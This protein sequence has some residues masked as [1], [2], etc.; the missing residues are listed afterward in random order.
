MPLDK[1]ELKRDAA[2]HWP[3]IFGAV[4]LPRDYTRNQPCPSCGGRDRFF[5]H[6]DFEDTGGCECRKCGLGGAD[7]FAVLQGFADMTFTRALEFVSDQLGLFEPRTGQLTSPVQHANEFRFPPNE[8]AGDTDDKRFNARSHKTL[9]EAVNAYVTFKATREETLR[10]DAIYPV[11]F[12]GDEPIYAEA[13]LLDEH[14]RKSTPCF[15]RLSDTS[16]TNGTVH[17]QYGKRSGPGIFAL[18]K[19]RLPF[20]G[21]D[22][23]DE[24]LVLV[25]G[26]KCQ[27]KATEAGIPAIAFMGGANADKL[28]DFDLGSLKGKSVAICFD[29]DQDGKSERWGRDAAAILM[30]AG[31]ESVKMID[32]RLLEDCPSTPKHGYDIADYLAESPS[33]RAAQVILE[34]LHDEQD[35]MTDWRRPI[36]ERQPPDN[37]RVTIDNNFA[38]IETKEGRT[39]EANA[40]RFV[41]MFIDEVLYCAPWKSWVVWDG[42]RWRRDDTGAIVAK[43]REVGPQVWIEANRC[44]GD[45]A[46]NA[47]RFAAK[48][49]SRQSIKNMVELAKSDPDIVVLP[50]QL[51]TQPMLFNCDNGTIDLATGKLRPH[52]LLDRLTQCSPVTYREDSPSVGKWLTF[53]DT[54]LGDPETTR[55]MQRL[56]GY[57]LTGSIDEHKLVIAHGDGANGKSTMFNILQA[58]FGP[59]YMITIVKSVLL[60]KPQVASHQTETMNLFGARVALSSETNDS[61]SL[62]EATVK[63]LTGGDTIRGSRKYEQTWQFDPTHKLILQTNHMPRIKGS[64]HAIWRRVLKIPFDVTFWDEDNGET[65]LPEHKCD[66]SLLGQLKAELSGIL[67]W[68]VIGC[69]QWQQD[70]LQPSKKVLKATESYKGQ[71]CVVGQF[72]DECCDLGIA[73]QHQEVKATVYE[74]YRAWMTSRGQ[75]PLSKPKFTKGLL[76]IPGISDFRDNDR[77]YLGLMIRTDC[78]FL[79]RNGSFSDA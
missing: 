49:C 27:Q 17:I 60:E 62:D 35:W 77:K 66:K 64:D 71:Q 76:R 13:R 42:K 15:Q 41:R 59:Q 39:D 56:V 1:N 32:L 10:I 14:G 18:N 19:G 65:G 58:M 79:E 51:D 38:R 4:G 20:W 16:W 43:A 29:L 40:R 28:R 69:M 74:T 34:V 23:P 25:E 33:G 5:A 53:L 2:G 73:E 11:G 12:K 68:A 46:D 47:R 72:V 21:R 3:E 61:D 55:F 78:E 67:H 22:V 9:P 63:D 70:G 75:W 26:P 24:T 37:M 7:G 44:D 54:V 57:F 48:S 50:S 31:V 30:N 36:E 45:A 8:I 52:D 6:A